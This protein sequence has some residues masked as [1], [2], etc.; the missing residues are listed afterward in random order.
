MRNSNCLSCKAEI[1]VESDAFVG[2]IV[3]CPDCGEEHEVNET[4]GSLSLG[5]APEIEESWGE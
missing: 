1:G 2:E 3:E 4:N 5:L